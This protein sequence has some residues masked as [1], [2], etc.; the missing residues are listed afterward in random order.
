MSKIPVRAA[1]VLMFLQWA[2]MPPVLA[3]IFDPET[4]RYHHIVEVI[5]RRT[6]DDEFTGLDDVIPCM[7]GLTETENHSRVSR[8]DIVLHDVRIRRR[9]EAALFVQGRNN[10][11]DFREKP[12]VRIP[13]WP[14]LC[15][16]F[17]SGGPAYVSE[18]RTY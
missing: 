16:F 18:H 1:A 15:F 6:I 10:R 9:V 11:D 13:E 12:Y 14:D 4:R 7:G 5:G 17:H 2:P 3:G 8:H